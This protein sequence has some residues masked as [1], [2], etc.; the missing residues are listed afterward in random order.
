VSDVR[1]AY[2]RAEIV[3]AP[4]TASAGTNIKVLE[5]MAMGRVVVG[6]PAGFNGLDVTNGVDVIVASTAGEM[7]RKIGELCSDGEAR[8]VIERHA[9]ETAIRYSWGE[10][11]AEQIGLWDRLAGT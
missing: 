11:A 1:D 4:L 7:A 9:R 6:T 5:A 2:R 3:L 8:R 10:I